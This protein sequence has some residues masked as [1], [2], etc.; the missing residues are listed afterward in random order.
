[1]LK[2]RE[3]MRHAATGA[4]LLP[5]LPS[6]SLAQGAAWPTRPVRIVVGYSAGGGSDSI[7]RLFAQLLSEDLGQTFIVENKPGAGGNIA[8]D[9]VAH[10]NDDH[11]L[12]FGVGAHVIN[13]SLYPKI[14]YDPIKDFSPLS[15]IALAPNMLVARPTLGV[16]TIKD[17]VAMAKADPGK[18]S[19]SSPGTGTPMHLAMEL[20]ASMAG[21]KLVHVPYKG[22]G[23]SVQSTLA[24]Q[25]DLL[26]MSVPTVLPHIGSGKLQALGVTG[27]T[28]NSQVPEVPT[29]EEAASLPGYEALAW[30]G[31]LAPAKMP[32]G[33]VNKLNAAIRKQLAKPEVRDKLLAQGFEPSPN[34]PEEFHRFLVEDME[35]WAKVVKASGAR[36]E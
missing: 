36:I 7:G 20:F 9:Y 26:T 8:A 4:A 35:K 33:S 12:L 29:V 15:L 25:T 34:S 32:P 6:L 27:R 2:R 5:A 28:R 3:F 13:A 19:Y 14:P 10:G 21:I 17:V 18:L 16:K 22:G 1:M 31:L 24:G 23:E 11:K 30:Y